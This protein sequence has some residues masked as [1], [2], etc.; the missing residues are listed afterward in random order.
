M[1]P[2]L[3]K[4]TKLIG[5]LQPTLLFLLYKFVVNWIYRVKFIGLQSKNDR[6]PAEHNGSPRESLQQKLNVGTF[7]EAH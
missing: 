3:I 6:R 1:A 7:V 2:W 4:E 5:V